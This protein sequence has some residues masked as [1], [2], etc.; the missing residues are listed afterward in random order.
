MMYEE[1]AEH[2]RQ[3][4]VLRAAVTGLM[5]ALIAGLLAFAVDPGKQLMA[6]GLMCAVSLLGAL[7]NHKHYER[8]ELHKGILRGY[9]AALEAGVSPALAAINSTCRKKHEAQYPFTH[10]VRLRTL[11][12]V[13]Y[14][15]TFLIGLVFVY[16][17]LSASPHAP[18]LP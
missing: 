17:A 1:H 12:A 11:W 18:R 6:G 13:I 14:C 8:Y 2:A 7:L 4:E 15:A 3:H 5:M 9:R 10:K 16:Q